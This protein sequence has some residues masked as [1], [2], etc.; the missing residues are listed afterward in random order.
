MSKGFALVVMVGAVGEG[1]SGRQIIAFLTQRYVAPADRCSD[2]NDVAISVPWR[3]TAIFLAKIARRTQMPCPC[4]PGGQWTMRKLPT[5]DWGHTAATSGHSLAP[6]ELPVYWLRYWPEIA[7]KDHRL[8]PLLGCP[9]VPATERPPTVMYGR[10][11]P[12]A[13]TTIDAAQGALRM[14]RYDDQLH[15]K[16]S[17]NS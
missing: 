7:L 9:E 8:L 14:A 11:S 17:Q 13:G 3:S 4:Q 6:V 2:K 10:V 15:Q 1:R 12:V 16:R 5:P